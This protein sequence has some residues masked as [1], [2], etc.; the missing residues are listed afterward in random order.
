VR[1]NQSYGQEPARLTGGRDELLGCGC[2]S[3]FGQ[4]YGNQPAVG[5]RAIRKAGLLLTSAFNIGP[6][7]TGS[8]EKRSTGTCGRR[9]PAL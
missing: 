9:R 1:Q 5:A 6:A 8:L 4:I 3:N 2:K 7:R